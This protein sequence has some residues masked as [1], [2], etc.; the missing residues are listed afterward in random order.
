M[1]FVG[2]DWAEDHHDVEVVDEAGRVL[3]RAG[4]PE[5]LEGV[6]RLHALI[7]EQMPAAARTFE[8][9]FTLYNARDPQTWP[10]LPAQPVP[11]WTLDPEVLG[12]TLS[13]LGKTAIPGLIA[14]AKEVGVQLPPGVD[15]PN[16]DLPPAVLVQALRGICLH[17]FPALAEGCSRTTSSREPGRGE[18]PASNARPFIAA[19]PTSTHAAI[20]ADVPRITACRASLLPAQ[21]A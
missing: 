10:D 20:R 15:D 17:Y 3:A 2:D 9:V 16:A 11:E 5:G 6:T 7:A 4:V 18:R 8:Q 1:L 19:P 14:H 13:A 21:M 12:R